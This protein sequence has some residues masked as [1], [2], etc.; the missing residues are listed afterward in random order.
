M[1][2]S[3]K[4]HADYPCAALRSLE[5]EVDRYVSGRV[6]LLYVATGAID[7]LVIPRPAT[8]ARADELWK[9]TCF[10]AFARQPDAENYTEFNFAPSGAWAA[11]RFARRRSGMGNLDNVPAPSTVFK[12][13]AKRLELAVT[14][15]L[16]KVL[17]LP[18]EAPWRAGIT[19][20]IEEASGAKSYWALA[21]PQ[22]NPDFHHADSF[23]LD[24]PVTH[25]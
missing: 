6:D 25:P 1:R 14:L 22:G 2:M 12:A 21:H 20:I 8:P 19:A 18:L 4:P 11:Y 23:A 10:E 9:H 16:S 7:Q 24:L 5:V 13:D 15:D 17:E 3:L